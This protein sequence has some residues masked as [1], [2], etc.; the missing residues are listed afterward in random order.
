MSPADRGSRRRFLAAS[1]AGL[2]AGPAA[3][4]SALG[5]SAAIDTPAAAGLSV[6]DFIPSPLHD[7]IRRGTEAA[8]LRA[9]I[10]AAIDQ[11]LASGAEL[12][13]PAGIYRVGGTLR[14]GA[15]ILGDWAAILQRT[16]RLDYGEVHER[17]LQIANVRANSNLKPVSIRAEGSAVIVGDFRPPSPTPVIEFNLGHLRGHSRIIGDLVITSAGRVA[18]GRYLSHE[19]LDAPA[20]PNRLIGLAVASAGLSRVEMQFAGMQCGLLAWG[21]FWTDFAVRADNCMDAFNLANANAVNLVGEAWYC[22]RGLVAD[23]CASQ[24]QIH[25][26]QVATDVRMFSCDVATLLPGYLEDA[27]RTSDGSGRFSLDLGARA[28][29][30]RIHGLT[31]MG[32]RLQSLRPGK[33]ALR[34]HGAPAGVRFVNCRNYVTAAGAQIDR[35]STGLIADSDDAFAGLFPA[36]RFPATNGV[37]GRHSRHNPTSSFTLLEEINRLLPPRNY[38]R[39]PPGGGATHVYPLSPEIPLAFAFA[40]AQ[41]ILVS[42]GVEDVIA[43][44]VAVRPAEIVVRIDNPGAREVHHN[45]AVYLVDIRTFGDAFE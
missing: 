31:I 18:N 39:L 4:A 29:V 45:D 13:F 5:A 3:A 16:D 41:A 34:L 12:V 42:G 21:S 6:L 1:A 37:R 25:T 7:S 27:D 44:V 17:F 15:P 20:A 40:N 30:S 23:G 24:F 26:E 36:G 28:D 8:D 38:G 2:V 14:I 33:R 11:A 19:G 10:Q 9:P 22:D 35:I 32:A 43:R